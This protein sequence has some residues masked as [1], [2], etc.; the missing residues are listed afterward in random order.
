M[1]TAILVACSFGCSRSERANV[2]DSTAIRCLDVRGT[3]RKFVDAG[4]E[5][6]QTLRLTSDGVLALAVRYTYME[7]TVKHHGRWSESG[8]NVQFMFTET[9]G[10]PVSESMTLLAKGDRLVATLWNKNIW[11]S[12]PP[13]FAR[14]AAA[15]AP[16]VGGAWRWV[17]TT[18]P[19]EALVAN[20]LRYTIE[21]RPDSSLIVLADCNRGR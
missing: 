10:M 18:T 15:A 13:E 16:L 8:G 20:G 1:T 5:V 19:M 12:A 3:A 17:G 2:P 11:G 7:P 4:D 9:A 21:F 6:L 14:V